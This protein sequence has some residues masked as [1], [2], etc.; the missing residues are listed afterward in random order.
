M[1]NQIE[2]PNFHEMQ[3]GKLRE[4]ASHMRVAL[5]KTATKQE[6]I[7]A[8]ERKL[9]GR[10]MPEFADSTTKVKP[11]YAKIRIHEDPNPGASNL[12]VYVNANG[13][14]ATIPR[15][16]DIIVPIRVVRV[17]NDATVNRRKQT[18]VA[19]NDG[20]ET[21]RETT[22]TVQSYPFQ[23]IEMT[24]GP[25]VKTAHELSKERAQ[26]PR[27]RY[28]QLFGHWPKPRE[29]SRAIEKG[30]IVLNPDEGLD[31]ATESLLGAGASEEN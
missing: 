17:L 18:L 29:L 3:I 12:P 4:Y 26:G 10:I 14:V 20:R 25:E 19:G 15:G 16:K 24:P 2:T 6:I 13:Y 5:S 21:F 27:K 11:G 1:S 31:T 22:V 23:V 30:L 28:R 9:N 7:E 8:I